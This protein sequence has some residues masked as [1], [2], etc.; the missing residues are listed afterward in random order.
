MR[1]LFASTDSIAVPLLETLA[2]KGICTAVFTTPDAPKKRGKGFVPT[3][4]RVKAEELGLPVFTPEHLNSPER[5]IVRS[6]GT[7]ALLSFSYGKIFGPKFLSLFKYTFN[8]HP[9]ALPLYRGCSPIF[10]VIRNRERESAISLQ[11]ISL[12]IDE[13]D[14]YASYPLKLDGTETSESL[15]K[16]ISEVAPGFVLSALE[17]VDN[18]IPYPQMGEASYTGFIKKDDGLI[19]WSESASSIHALIRACYPWPKAWCY[20]NGAPF[21]ITGVHSSSFLPFEECSEEPGTVIALD[22]KKGLKIATGDGYLYVSH[23]LPPMKK[24]MDAS[25]FVNGCRSI[26]GSRLTSYPSSL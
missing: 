26:I 1:L 15:E 13:G 19:D 17:S 3:P 22:K 23:V 14:I 9:S 7:D 2:E 24:E 21:I 16:V 12:K 20:F 8:V 11:K 25:S 5:D 10:N 6:L 18:I 4:I